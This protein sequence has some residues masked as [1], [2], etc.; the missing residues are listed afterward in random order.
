MSSARGNSDD[1]PINEYEQKRL[2]NVAKVKERLQALGVPSL[3]NLLLPKQSV[4]KRKKMHTSDAATDGH[5]LRPRTQIN[6]SEIAKGHIPNENI[7]NNPNQETNGDFL[8]DNEDLGT[9]KKRNGRGI[10][11]LDDIF[12]RTPNM[13]K[14]KIMLNGYGQPVDEDSRKLSSAIGCQVR[15]TLSIGCDDWR[16]VD[17]KM[18]LQVWD[19]IKEKYDIDDAAQKWFMLTAGLKWKE[20]KADLKR[21]YFDETLSDEELI[22]INDK[23]K[24]VNPNDWKYLIAFWRTADSKA[25]TAR[26]KACRAK[27]QQLHTSRSVSHASTS[28]NMSKQLGRPAR[29]DEVFVKTHTRKNGEPIRQAAQTI[30]ELQDILEV[31]PEL[32]DRTIQEGNAF[33]VVCGLKEPRRRVRVLGVGPTPQEIG[34]PGLKSYVPTRIQMEALAREKAESEKATLQQR[35]RELEEQLVDERMAK[36]RS[37]VENISQHGSNSRHQVSPR[38]LEHADESHHNVHD[39]VGDDTDNEDYEHCNEENLLGQSQDA[40][41]SVPA[42]NTTATPSVVDAP[43]FA[44]GELV[45]KEVI[46]YALVRSNQPVAKGTVISTNPNTIV[47]G[48]PLGKQYCELVVNVVMKKD[49]ILPRPQDGMESMAA[50]HLMEI[51]WPYKKVSNK[52]SKPS[53]DAAASARRC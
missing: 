3:N 6:Y 38:P 42:K 45:G 10:T 20:F 22:A 40:P 36:Q 34:T 43:R 44:H 2:A 17:I 23:K 31:Y 12:S 16:L 4:K 28:H 18:K 11:R 19:D 32:K 35:V 39:E 29:R 25:R 33:A 41:L 37:N 52:A 50:A 7:A 46:L 49:A 1:D 21:K 9:C 5:Y 13:P 8:L 53:H 15:K 51:A 14:I 30:N 26:A 47:G 27:V 48:Q 24:I